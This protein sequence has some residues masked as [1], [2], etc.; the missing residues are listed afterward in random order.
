MVTDMFGKTVS[1]DWGVS[2]M[3]GHLAWKLYCPRIIEWVEVGVGRR[4]KG[5]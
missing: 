4:T 3:R 5:K 1:G 2:W